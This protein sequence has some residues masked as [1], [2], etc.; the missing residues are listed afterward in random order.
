MKSESGKATINDL[1]YRVERLETAVKML[2]VSP[3]VKPTPPRHGTLWSEKEDKYLIESFHAFIGGRAKAHGRLPS[4]IAFRI[5][6]LYDEN[7][8]VPYYEKEIKEVR[9]W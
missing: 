6:K 7:R 3:K 5:K 1:M 2:E 8:V 4:G 9:E